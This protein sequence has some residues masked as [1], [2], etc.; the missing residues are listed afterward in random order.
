MPI[1]VT[2]S[3]AAQQF[4]RNGDAS[5]RA[6]VL[7]AVDTQNELTAGAAVEKRMSFAR[8]DPP[9]PDGTRV[10]TGR[11]RRSLRR[12]K[13]RWD[14]DVCV[15]SIGSNVVYFGVHEFGYAGEQH[16]ASFQRRTPTRFLVAGNTKTISVKSA[17][18]LGLFT[19]GGKPR[20]GHRIVGG[21]QTVTVRAFARN[22]RFPARMMVQRTFAERLPLYQQAIEGAAGAAWITGG[23][24][25]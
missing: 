6:A 1:T 5:V 13:A 24:P 21:D 2:I 9:Q 11:L 20:A 8:N 3:P 12:S 15:S 4:L 23:S 14:G 10:Q 22:A 25:S 16:V 17:Q 19:R 18:R 7:R